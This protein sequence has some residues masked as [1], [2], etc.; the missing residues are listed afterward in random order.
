MEIQTIKQSEQ[1]IEKLSSL[2]QKLI[3][4]AQLVRFAHKFGPKHYTQ[5]QM[6]GLLILK[7]RSGLSYREFVTWLF[8]SKWPEWLNLPSIPSKTT[9]HKYFS[10]IGLRLIRFLNRLALQTQQVFRLAIDSTGIDLSGASKHYEKRIFR[11]RSPHLKLSILA[12]VDSKTIFDW[13]SEQKHVHDIIHAKRMLKRIK[14]KDLDIFADKAYDGEELMQI[15]DE[16]SNRIY[17]PIR[18]FGNKRPKSGRLRKKLHKVFDKKYYNKGRN[19]VECIMYL[20][21]LDR[22]K[23]RSKKKLNKNKEIGWNILAYNLKRLAKAIRLLLANLSG[24]HLL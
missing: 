2:V 24:Q 15:A 8:E 9:L 7:A 4:S 20:I 23:I 5:H 14:L 21:K 16:K 18:D 10:R 17:C 13:I 19:P 3:H 6:V 1:A 22:I 11:E 12:D